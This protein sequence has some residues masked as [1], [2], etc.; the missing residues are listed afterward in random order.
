MKIYTLM[1]NTACSSDFSA[2]HGLSLYIE[3]AS[4]NILFDA[5]QS[6]NFLHNAEKM[7]VDLS[8]ADVFVLSHGHFDHSGGLPDFL[9]INSKAKIYLSK[10]AFADYYAAD[11]RYI[12][13]DKQ[14]LNEERLVFCDEPVALTDTITLSNGNNLPVF[15]P[16]SSYGLNK[17]ADGQPL[18]D[19]FKHEQYLTVEENGKKIVFSGCSHKGILNI[20]NW[21]KPDILIGGFHFMTLNCQEQADQQV[22]DQ[23]AKLLLQSQAQYY[24]C[25]CTGLEQYAYLKKLL[26]NNLHY[27][28]GG[29][30]IEL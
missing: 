8:K 23:A 17:I 11:G 24:T 6:S 12:G 5:G 9:K 19:D 14:L 7:H 1:E 22:L 21:L 30:I 26:P 13:L 10:Y 15:Y 27:L 29:T 25:H 16:V 3:T 20:I 28:S 18:P 4:L 2:E